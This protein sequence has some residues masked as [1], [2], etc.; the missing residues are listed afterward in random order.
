MDCRLQVFKYESA[1]GA[2]CAYR[3]A[4][5]NRNK[6]PYPANFVC[7]LPVKLSPGK[8]NGGTVFNELFGDKS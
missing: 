8:S 3:F 4:V 5:V 1:Q 2:G 6:S 7:M